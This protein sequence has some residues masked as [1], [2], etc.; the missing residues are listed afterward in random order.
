MCSVLRRME[1]SVGG[2]NCTQDWPVQSLIEQVFVGG[3]LGNL[4]GSFVREAGSFKD[5]GSEGKVASFKHELGVGRCSCLDAQ[6]SEHGVRLP[7]A[8]QHDGF[9]ADVGTEKGGRAART[10]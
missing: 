1:E 10:W 9:G 2:E 4:N 7:A 3:E 8:K 6:V 5:T